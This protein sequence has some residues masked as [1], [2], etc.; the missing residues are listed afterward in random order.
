MQRFEDSALFRHPSMT[1]SDFAVS[2]LLDTPSVVVVEPSLDDLLPLVGALT[3]AGFQ[4]TS[5][6]TFI[7]A[8]E[9][10]NSQPPS[11]LVTTLR[12]GLY[13]GLHLV[14]RGKVAKP[15]MA[16]LVTSPVADP[17]LQADAEAMGATFMLKP[18]TERDL[19]A[20]ALRTLYSSDRSL[21]P[22]RPPFERR[23]SERRVLQGSFDPGR[24]VAERRRGA[25]SI[26]KGAIEAV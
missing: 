21:A 3:A 8:R 4:V 7:Q 14:L 17:V 6:G 12:L 11:I 13:N 2:A 26:V 9:L 20:A 22:L 5:A 1:A 18:V 23:A 10:L 24:R 25:L 15:E 16:A 19:I